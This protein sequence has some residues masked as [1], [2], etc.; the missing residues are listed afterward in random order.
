MGS[1]PLR[2]VMD[3]LIPRA[4]TCVPCIERQIPP[5]SHQG[6]L[7]LILFASLKLMTVVYSKRG[8]TGA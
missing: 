6:S 8:E 7:I 1:L 2:R 3:P 4:G 5:R